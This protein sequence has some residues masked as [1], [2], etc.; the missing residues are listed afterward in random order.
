MFLVLD[1]ISIAVLELLVVWQSRCSDSLPIT[2]ES[3]APT[4]EA[5][6]AGTMRLGSLAATDTKK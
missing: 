4:G 6:G 2:G 5:G 1:K 3:T